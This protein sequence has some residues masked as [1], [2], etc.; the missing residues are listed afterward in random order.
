MDEMDDTSVE[1]EL[2]R[3]VGTL[4]LGPLVRVSP[5]ASLRETARTMREANVSSALVGQLPR[6]IVTER[7]LT[8]AL[9]EGFGPDDAVEQVAGRIPVWATTTSQVFDVAVMMLRHQL[10][11]LVIVDP[12]GEEVGIVSMRDVFALLLPPHLSF[13]LAD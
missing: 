13:S 4:R 10:R 11:H 9:A 3:Q 7:D 8:R 12:D 2:R 6:R 5:G 1:D